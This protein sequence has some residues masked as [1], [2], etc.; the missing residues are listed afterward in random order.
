MCSMIYR[1]GSVSFSGLICISSEVSCEVRLL[2]TQWQLWNI[3]VADGAFSSIKGRREAIHLLFR[4]DTR[5]FSPKPNVPV[6]FIAISAEISH[7]AF[8]VT[9]SVYMLV[10]VGCGCSYWGISRART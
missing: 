8:K 6:I 5:S 3:S 9:C 1:I 4:E 7:E 2:F 10:A